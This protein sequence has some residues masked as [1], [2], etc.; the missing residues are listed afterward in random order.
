[1]IAIRTAHMLSGAQ[2]AGSGTRV[3]RCSARSVR[4]VPRAATFEG[5]MDDASKAKMEE[6]ERRF[7]MADVDGQVVWEEHIATHNMHVQPQSTCTR[8]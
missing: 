6:L 2:R 1:M 7:K 5:L 3:P 8:V 4:V